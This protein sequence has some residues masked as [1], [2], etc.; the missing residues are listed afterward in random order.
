MFGCRKAVF[1]KNSCLDSVIKYLKL[2]DN[3][4]NVSCDSYKSQE[5]GYALDS[6]QCL[7]DTV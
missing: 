1:T 2:F 4:T 6:Q 5:Q 7:F 3:L